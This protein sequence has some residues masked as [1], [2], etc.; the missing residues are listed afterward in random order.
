MLSR[1]M[2]KNGES[3]EKTLQTG[4]ELISEIPKQC[5]IITKTFFAEF[6]IV[7][8]CLASLHKF[9]KRKSNAYE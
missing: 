8:A 6:L 5:L 4:I 2:I 7:S 9:L 3:C 1:C